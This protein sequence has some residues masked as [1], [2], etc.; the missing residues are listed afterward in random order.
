MQRLK[1][2]L[3]DWGFLKR[4]GLRKVSRQDSGVIWDMIPHCLMWGISR[5]RNART[6][7]G[8]NSKKS[9]LQLG[10]DKNK[11]DPKKREILR[12]WL[13]KWKIDVVCLQE[14]KLDKIDWRIIQS[15]WGNRFVDWVAL[16]A[17]NT[18]GGVLLLWDK[19]VLELIDS[20]VGKFSVSCL[21]KGLLDGFEW[22]G[23]GLYGPTCDEIRPDFWS[24]VKNVRQQWAQPWCVFGDFNVVRFPSER[25]GCSRLSASMSDFSDFIDDLNLVDLP[26]H[27]GQ[28][29]WCNG[30]SN[31]SMSRIDRVLV[32]SDWEEQYPD[33]FQKLLPKPISDHAPLLLEVGG[34]AGGKRA[35]KFE[36]M[37]LKDP[38]FVNKVRGWWS[39]YSFMG[40]PSYVLSQKLKALKEDLKLW[41]KQVFGDVGLKRQQLECELQS[42]DEKEGT[43]FLTSEERVLREACKAELGKV[44]HLEEVS[45]RQKSRVLWLKEGDNNTKFFH[46]MANS[47][48]RNN[49]MERVEVD[50]SVYEV[51]SEVREK[52]VQFYASLYQEQEPWRPTVDGLDFDMI[53]EEEKALLERRFERDEVLQVVKDLQGDK[54]PGPDGFT[55]AFFQK[56]WPV[57]EEDIM[58]FFGE[59]HTYCKFE[60]SLNA[61]FIALI[62][63]KQNAT[64][65]RDFRPISL[66]GSVYK[67]L[68]KV[69]ANR[70]KGVLDHIISE[71]QNSFIGG[72]KILD[73]VLIANECLDSRLKSRLPGIICK[74]DIE[75]AYDHVH[76]GSLLYLLKR[77]GFGTKWCQWI[78]ACISSVQFSVLVNGSP[79]GFFR[80]SRGIRQGDPLSPLLF[81]LIMEVLSRMLRKVELE[82][83]IQGFSAGSNASEGLRISHLL[84]ADD[85][86][87]FCDAD[88]GQVSYI[89]MV[90]SCFEAVTGLRVNMAKS[91]MVPVGEVGNIAMLADSLDCR[92]GSLPLAYL[93]M[94]LGASYKAV[95]VWDPIIEK[96]ERR[97]EK[98]QRNFLWGGM[99]EEFK[100]HLVGWDKVCTPKEK[101]GLGV[102]SL[103][104]FNKALLGKWLWRF[105]LEEHHL[106]RR[107]L[108]A[109]YGVDFGGWRTSR[110]RSPYGCGVW[111]GIV[112]GWDD[113][114]QHIEFVVGLGNRIR[115]WQDKWCEDMALMDRF[116]TLY[117]CSAQREVTIAAVLMRPAAGG[118]CEW[119]VTFGRDFNDWEIDLV[120]DF[121]QLLAS[122]TPTNEGPDRLRWKGRK[123]GVFTSRS[124]YHA[125]TD[126]PGVPFPWKGIWAVKAPPRVSFFIW[127]A[128]WGRILTCDN[129]MRRGYTMVSRC[130]LCCSDG[131]TVDHLLLHCPISHVLW[132]FL[133]RSFHVT[134]VVPRSVKDLFFGWRNWFG[135]HHSDIWNLAPLCLMWNVWLE[136]NSRIFED[137]QSSVDHLLEKF[138]S[139]LFDWSRVWG[140]TT[141]ASV[142][143]FL[144]SLSFVSDSHSIL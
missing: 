103:T 76:W 88:L 135:K 138:T 46:Q 14:T 30:S 63:K 137:T 136:R 66:I 129:L 119:N 82:G 143:D 29:T 115:F 16:D 57:L 90:L 54:A 59:V 1:L 117:A 18:A 144:V 126:R 97:I 93:G 140:F 71:S 31:P 134:W 33:V 22:V 19:R 79:E 20:A 23:T 25:L 34:M 122:K 47:H 69:L 98:L 49:H 72:R 114:F 80:S 86:I 10:L 70:L 107:V 100:H 124:F 9:D 2:W 60:R 55:M 43:S 142:A 99:G 132:S 53:S 26:L 133:F 44:A 84:F 41:N 8:F 64:N 37:W 102:R 42:F 6:F 101:G 96:M 21:W 5:E 35:F 85:T 92:V 112:L 105:G 4:L 24:E 111:K 131:E 7:E 73:S 62:P 32:S 40:T 17:V 125:L 65:I 11:N 61:S 38:N 3:S 48:R 50:G 27:G 108:V 51:E 58:G 110:T 67:I 123:D 87:L 116:P 68:S 77:M 45:W 12:N 39:S 91:E 81:L 75:K 52:V 89:R 78:E 104:L 127:T 128:T 95:A 106:W 118:P 56:C 120:V 36:N 121:F 113:Y 139:S 141:A 28:Y 15:I 13:R 109:K 130:C 83:L 94:P 74:L